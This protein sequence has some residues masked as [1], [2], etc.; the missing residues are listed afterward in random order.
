MGGH[1]M[2]GKFEALEGAL[3]ALRGANQYWTSKYYLH[4]EQAEILYNPDS[5]K[6][7]LSAY[8]IK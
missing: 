3:I 4:F 7:E 6:F 5:K 2:S 1:F 8:W